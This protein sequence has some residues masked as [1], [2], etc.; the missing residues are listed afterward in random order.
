MENL[1]NVLNSGSNCNMTETFATLSEEFDAAARSFNGKEEAINLTMLLQKYHVL[2]RH[3][4]TDAGEKSALA[5]SLFECGLHVLQDIRGKRDDI[6]ASLDV[7][8]TKNITTLF[9]RLLEPDS[10]AYIPA[11]APATLADIALD[12]IRKAENV[13]KNNFMTEK[14]H[15]PDEERA[16]AHKN[17]LAAFT[18]VALTFADKFRE[19]VERGIANVETTHPFTA[20]KPLVLKQPTAQT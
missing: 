20:S 2:Q 17:G 9:A 1:Y 16:W 6:T 10:I 18:E 7:E 8:G 3:K 4:V 19:A 11:A 14:R 13:D 12:L 5:K 15:F